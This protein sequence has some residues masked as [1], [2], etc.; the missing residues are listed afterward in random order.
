M[1]QRLLC[2]L[3]SAALLIG[4]LPAPLHAQ[5][6]PTAGSAT[7]AS[8]TAIPAAEEVFDAEQLDSLLAPIALYP[9]VLLTQVLMATA[10]PLEIVAA[11][12]W[13]AE[14]TNR[15]MKGAALEKALD[16]EPW[17]PAVKSLIPFPQV[18]DMLNQN[19]EWT[20]QLGYAMQVQQ[21]DVFEAVQRL[22]QQ[23]R[24]AGH[25]QSSSEQAVRVEAPPQ[26]AP[27]PVIVIEPAKPDI[28]YV[29]VYNPT[30]V[31]GAWPYPA[32][33]PI[34]YPPPPGYVVGSALA[35]GLAFGAGVAITA[36]LWGWARP[37]WGC[38]WAGYRGSGNIN[39]NI[40]HY[41]RISV[42]R[43]WRGSSDGHWRPNNPNYRP[44]GGYRPGGPVGQP[45]RPGH[46]PAPRHV[47]KPDRVGQPSARPQGRPSVSVPS[48]VVRPPSG[49][50]SGNRPEAG[51]PLR[52]GSSGQPSR[53]AVEAPRP[54]IVRPPARPAEP[55]RPQASAF[56]SLR[57]GHRASEFGNR[58]AQSRQ[59]STGE[60]RQR[61]RIGGNRPRAGAR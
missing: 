18:L 3:A 21:P 54:A 11:S 7:G 50:G 38:C 40:N 48:N 56:G 58:G 42:H 49:I 30:V 27:Q 17:D 14:G 5:T 44:G 12:R 43:P 47:T 59:L 15:E 41:N 51:K 32:T 55:T 9:D 26:G 53:P 4:T 28:V 57:D 29:P 39:I 6:I 36:A 60:G 31:Y 24:A 37:N 22:R 61:D 13:L 1:R 8:D 46:F 23:A 2:Y 10:N 20:Q 19:L 45:G 25:L 52:P 33:P 34:Y 35:A 16:S